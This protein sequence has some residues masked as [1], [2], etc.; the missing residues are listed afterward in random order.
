[1]RDKDLETLACAAFS[2]FCSSVTAVSWSCV[3]RLRALAALC[4]FWTAL[5]TACW[6]LSAAYGGSGGGVEGARGAGEGRGRRHGRGGACSIEA[7]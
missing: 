2:A 5:S 7:R 1:M 3:A 4:S 6:A